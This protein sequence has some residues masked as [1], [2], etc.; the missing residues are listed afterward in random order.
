VVILNEYPAN[1]RFRQLRLVVALEEKSAVVLVH[2]RSD[3]I[4]AWDF[5][6]AYL[7]VAPDGGAQAVTVFSDLSRLV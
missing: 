2:L 3:Q 6:L 1:S 5:C 7:Q 4:H